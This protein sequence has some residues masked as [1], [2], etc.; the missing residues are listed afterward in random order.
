MA[1]TLQGLHEKIRHYNCYC[2]VQG[3]RVK[4]EVMNAFMQ[5]VVIYKQVNVKDSEGIEKSLE[6]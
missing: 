5:G 1:N 4:A 2:P 6:L 3:S